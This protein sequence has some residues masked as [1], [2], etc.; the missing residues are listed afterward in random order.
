MISAVNKFENITTSVYRCEYTVRR[1]NQSSGV[2]PLVERVMGRLDWCKVISNTPISG[3]LGKGA[4]R[5]ETWNA[6]AFCGFP[7][8]V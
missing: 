4:V 2:E 7:L 1:S 3:L 5:Y 6:F 8:W